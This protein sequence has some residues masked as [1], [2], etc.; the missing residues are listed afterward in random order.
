[1]VSA[2]S[3]GVDEVTSSLPWV[4]QVVFTCLDQQYLEVVIEVGQTAC[5][6]TP[7][8]PTTTDDDIDLVWDGH[9]YRRILI[10]GSLSIK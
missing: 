1:M 8:A 9:C 3:F 5:W 4:V 7:R 2:I 6:D 10:L